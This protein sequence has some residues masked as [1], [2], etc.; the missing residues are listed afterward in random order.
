[1]NRL[2]LQ[3]DRPAYVKHG[4]PL[5]LA[6]Y[7]AWLVAPALHQL[8]VGHEHQGGRYESCPAAEP[9]W[10]ILSHP[11]DQPCSDPDHHHHPRPVHDAD[12]CLSCRL[13]PAAIAEI[14]LV[15]D[16]IPPVQVTRCVS[17]GADFAPAAP[18]LLSASPRGPP[19][20]PIA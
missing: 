19:P 5:L 17:E 20:T 14:P 18:A 6:L 16:P 7:V 1:M 9:D 11:P 8:H 13:G 15:G 2:G 4:A 3:S 12:H 10:R